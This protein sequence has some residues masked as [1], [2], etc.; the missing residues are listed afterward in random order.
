[1]MHTVFQIWKFWDPLGW[2]LVALGILTLAWAVARWFA[3]EREDPREL[4]KH[5]DLGPVRWW[6]EHRRRSAAVGLGVGMLVLGLLAAQYRPDPLVVRWIV[7]HPKE[8]LGINAGLVVLALLIWLNWD[9]LPR[10]VK[11]KEGRAESRFL[12]PS[13][14]WGALEFQDGKPV[15]PNQPT[16]VLLAYRDRSK[17]SGLGL[18]T[19]QRKPGNLLFVSL[20]WETLSRHLLVVGAQ[21]S[22][23]TTAFFGHVMA[24]ANAPFVYQDSKAELPFRAQF[25]DLP[26]WGLDVRGHLSRSGVWNPLEEMQTREDMDLIVDYVF[27]VNPHDANP[28]VREMSRTM[29]GAILKSRRWASLQEIAQSIRLTEL[30]PFLQG[31]EPI[32]RDLMK[33]PKSQ[34]P[35]LQDI[36]TTLTRWESPRIRS[37]TE[38]P[39]T[40]SLDDFIRHGGYVMNCEMSDGLRAPVHLFWAMLLGRLRNRA[41]GSSP[42][43]LLLD[44]FGDAGRL[45]NIERALVLLRSKGVSILAGIQNLGLLEEVYERSA[46]AVLNGFG[47]RIWLTR[48]LD[49]EL[50]EKLSRAL[51]KWTRRMPAAN[52]QS[53][54]S[55]KECDLMPLD[56]WT[57]WSQERA[58]LARMHGFTYWLPCSLPIPTTP[59]GAP[60]A[61]DDPWGDESQA[62][63]TEG[64]SMLPES[65][66]THLP[67]TPPDP[68]ETNPNRPGEAS[69]GAYRLSGGGNSEE[70]WL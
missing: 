60:S 68:A 54:E 4:L 67:A 21:G 61:P 36:V 9:G 19:G 41:E 48:N 59:L 42:V 46:K 33:E 2:V 11:K 51:G 8:F 38:G 13:E 23:K 63:E 56:A 28:W 12:D 47:S 43:L 18:S 70:D 16:A 20:R 39:S 55:E 5:R 7:G 15:G 53:K 26:V 35:V 22:G 49:E 65:W 40:V 14:D 17:A 32:W 52:S 10:Y 57:L 69:P 64:S 24:S 1:M 30:E 45:P 6:M 31:L 44:E 50:R 25:P 3:V 34:V 62:T 66:P 29:F 58:A 37:I 27:P